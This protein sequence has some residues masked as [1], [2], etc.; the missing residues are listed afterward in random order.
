MDICCFIIIRFFEDIFVRY[1]ARQSARHDNFR[2]MVSDIFLI[3]LEKARRLRI[4]GGG[5]FDDG[6]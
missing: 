2:I 3:L 1:L 4:P 6:L 5:R